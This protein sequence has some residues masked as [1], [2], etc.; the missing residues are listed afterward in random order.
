MHVCVCKWREKH[1]L[2]E[3]A[4]GIEHRS[5]DLVRRSFTFSVLSQT[6]SPIAFKNLQ[7]D[8]AIAML[9]N[10]TQS[11]AKQAKLYH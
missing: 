9:G 3:W 1:N 2:Q 6:T 10:E 7:L 5:S 8:L 4:L 11:Q